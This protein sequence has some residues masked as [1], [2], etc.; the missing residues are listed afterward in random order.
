ML[1]H[2]FPFANLQ[3]PEKWRRSWL[4]YWFFYEQPLFSATAYTCIC[5]GQGRREWTPVETCSSGINGRLIIGFSQAVVQGSII[6][7]CLW[8]TGNV[9][10]INYYLAKPAVAR[11]NLFY[12]QQIVEYRIS[13]CLERP[14]FIGN[15]FESHFVG[16]FARLKD[17]WIQDESSLRTWKLNPDPPQATPQ[18]PSQGHARQ[19]RFWVNMHT[20]LIYIFWI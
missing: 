10:K 15:L 17:I 4:S 20:V 6:I 18:P 1:S 3:L 11:N 13:Y 16:F 7:I 12:L 8:T 9:A 19:C 14:A 2:T 5:G